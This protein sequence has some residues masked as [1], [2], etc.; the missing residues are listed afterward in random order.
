MGRR[1]VFCSAECAANNA[2]TNY[3]NEDN[4]KKRRKKHAAIPKKGRSKPM[5]TLKKHHAC[6]PKG[7]F[8]RKEAIAVLGIGACY[9]DKILREM[10]TLGW[11]KYV[12]FATWKAVKPRSVE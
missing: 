1:S 5:E 12:R 10:Q 11:V 9:A 6:L 7:E 2:F 8:S 4:T 3:H